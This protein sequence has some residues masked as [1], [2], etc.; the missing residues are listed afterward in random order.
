MSGHAV[1]TQPIYAEPRCSTVIIHEAPIRIFEN[2]CSLDDRVA[3]Y[4]SVSFSISHLLIDAYAE[5]GLRPDFPRG[6]EHLEPLRKRQQRRLP[7]VDL[8]SNL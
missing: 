4:T 3:L 6:S 8:T 7:F 2:A 5:L 1:S